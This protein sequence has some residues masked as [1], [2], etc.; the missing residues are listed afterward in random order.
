MR[1]CISL[2]LLSITIAVQWRANRQPLGD[3]II[4]QDK[5]HNRTNGDYSAVMAYVTRVRAVSRRDAR[6]FDYAFVSSSRSFLGFRIS[7]D[8][9]S[10]PSKVILSTHENGN[11]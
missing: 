6:G 2:S 3:I 8:P 10:L 9:Q 1:K 5:Q 11:V 4:V 7:P